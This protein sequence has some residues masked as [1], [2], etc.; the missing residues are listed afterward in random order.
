MFAYISIMIGRFNM[1]EQR[2]SVSNKNWHDLHKVV[3]KSI[4]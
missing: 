3:E 1:V 4:H 2:V